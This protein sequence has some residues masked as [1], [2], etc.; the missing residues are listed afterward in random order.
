MSVF[1][2]APE[3]EKL[4][5]STPPARTDDEFFCALKEA[6]DVVNEGTEDDLPR[7]ELQQL[8]LHFLLRN[9]EQKHAL[10]VTAM[11]VATEAI[12]A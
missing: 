1:H 3:Y 11:L 12:M 4:I 6:V 2:I 10:F 9:I 8:F 7:T 5:A